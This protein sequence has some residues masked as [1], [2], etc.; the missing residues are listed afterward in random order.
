MMMLMMM[1]VS[2][3]SDERT[4]HELVLGTGLTASRSCTE[5][6]RLHDQIVA[7]AISHLPPFN[8]LHALFMPLIHQQE[9]VRR[10]AVIASRIRRARRRP[11]AGAYDAQSIED[12]DRSA[13]IHRGW[14]AESVHAL[15]Q[16]SSLVRLVG[17]R[18]HDGSWVWGMQSSTC[19]CI[20]PLPC[21]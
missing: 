15:V 7:C 4:H 8:T 1:T 2:R 21:P 19:L 16:L 13:T 5:D 6:S 11:D 20:A 9:C 17:C 12:Q 3:L 10:L 14:H 18:D